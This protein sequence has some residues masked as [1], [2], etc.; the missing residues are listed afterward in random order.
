MPWRSIYGV[1]YSGAKV[2]GRTAWLADCRPARGGRLR[3]VALDPLGKLAGADDRAA[4]NA[5][6]VRRIR[7]S[8]A[9]LWA[10]N[11]PFGLPAE[12]LPPGESSW[13]AQ[14][15]HLKSWGERAYEC[16]VACVGR[17]VAAGHRM[18]VRRATDCLHRT[19]FDSY[20]YRKNDAC[21][22]NAEIL[23]FVAFRSSHRPQE[24][25]RMVPFPW[26]MVR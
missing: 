23:Q 19:P 26:R 18:H 9:A 15:R 4:V 14:F 16:G 13:A 2:A 25:P 5:E 8:S 17:A 10:L 11:F 12:A 1:D 3:L 22:I 21:A 6:L 7:A 24:S 20:H